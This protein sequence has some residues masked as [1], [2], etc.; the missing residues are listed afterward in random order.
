MDA[1][2]LLR[3]GEDAY[4]RGDYIQAEENFR[5]ALATFEEE[6]DIAHQ[7]EALNNLAAAL[8]QMDK[9]NEAE[10][11]FQRLVPLCEECLGS[12]HPD[13]A[14]V[15]N[16]VAAFYLDQNKYSIAEPYYDK[17]R[18]ILELDKN[19]GHAGYIIIL[20]GLSKIYEL[21]GRD[22]QAQELIER[23]NG[24]RQHNFKIGE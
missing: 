15:L 17:A 23:V 20:D 12:D 11:Y 9:D 16:N 24:L 22:N 19:K 1:V 18:A 6:G 14:I 13:F 2:T 4:E 5:E 8:R 7:A 3:T 21:T 10:P